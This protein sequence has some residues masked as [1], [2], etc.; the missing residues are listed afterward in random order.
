MGRRAKR[1]RHVNRYVREAGS[2]RQADGAE[3]GMRTMVFAGGALK[4]PQA[5]WPGPRARLE[6]VGVAGDGFAG[7]AGVAASCF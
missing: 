1:V 3:G 2:Y 6:G 4:I 7:A 5:V